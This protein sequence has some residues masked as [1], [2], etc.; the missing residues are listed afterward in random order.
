M[1]IKEVE[2]KD[3]KVAVVD[4]SMHTLILA[5][6]S[7]SWC[8]PCQ[9]MQ[10]DFK[11]LAKETEG[12]LNI[13]V[14]DVEAPGASE[15]MEIC[16][17]ESIPDLKVY[18]QRNI[19]AQAKGVLTRNQMD[20]LIAPYLRTV[21]QQRTMMLESKIELLLSVDQ[22]DEALEL[23][24]MHLAK[25]PDDVTAKIVLIGVYVKSGN[26]ALA[27]KIIDELPEE[28]KKNK[29]AKDAIKLVEEMLG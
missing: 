27:K 28:I 2:A 9:S 3:F 20:A 11:Q 12:R 1:S 29:K 13:A 15:V 10:K 7:T 26:I 14:F 6:F 21:E 16:K 18:D 25:F 5:V 17:V 19:V 4:S 22:I 23:M 24:N 8:E